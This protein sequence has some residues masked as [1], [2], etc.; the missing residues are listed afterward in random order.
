M[1]IDR[2]QVIRGDDR[3]TTPRYLIASLTATIDTNEQDIGVNEIGENFIKLVNSDQ[4][5]KVGDAIKISLKVPLLD[6]IVSVPINGN[7][8]SITEDDVVVSYD[9]PL[10]T[11][12]RIL[13]ILDRV[14]T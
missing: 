2:R 6:Q 14:C 5:Q 7:I 13:P 1:N 11:W 9:H 8:E 3:R 10:E 12:Q 4:E